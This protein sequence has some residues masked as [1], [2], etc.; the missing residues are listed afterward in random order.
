MG[1]GVVFRQCDDQGSLLELIEPEVVRRDRRTDDRGVEPVLE[2]ALLHL[3]G[4]HLAD[5]L[6]SDVRH[7]DPGESDDLRHEAVG[8]RPGEAEAED[9]G[10]TAADLGDIG[11][12]GIDVRQDL[13]RAV[14]EQPA[15][16]RE[17]HAAGGPLEQLG[18]ELCFELPD[19]LRQGRLC[20]V[21]LLRCTS[22]VT[23]LGDREEVAQVPQFHGTS[24]FVLRRAVLRFRPCWGIPVLGCR[25]QRTGDFHRCERPFSARLRGGASQSIGN[26]YFSIL[27]WEPTVS[28]PGTTCRTDR[29][30]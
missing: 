11:A 5:H 29:K 8:G 1:E 12:R 16:L 25:P 6:Q 9:A 23:L 20:H 18:A 30:D 13:P 14:H 17:V 28:T 7:A 3:R 4:E 15:R 24:S 26:A 2:Q 22:E 27:M 21:E 10:G 19:L